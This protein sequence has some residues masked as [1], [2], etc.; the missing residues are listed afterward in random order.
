MKYILLVVTSLVFAGGPALA[1]QGGLPALQAQVNALQ[2]QNTSLEQQVTSLQTSLGTLQTQINAL[3]SCSVASLVGTY[4]FKEFSARGQGILDIRATKGTLVADGQGNATFSAVDTD[5]E[6]NLI[7]NSGATRS[8]TTAGPFAVTYVVN[9][10][11]TGS[12]TAGDG[13]LPFVL[14]PGG[15]I[16]VETR[17]N[18]DCEV[19]ASAS[20]DLNLGV[21]IRQ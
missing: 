13:S 2:A 17:G 3:T 11:C 7:A 1:Q 10:D 4:I 16:A 14:V 21:F 15:A 19:E 8:T 18:S 20:C 12:L 9:A 6:I 5:L